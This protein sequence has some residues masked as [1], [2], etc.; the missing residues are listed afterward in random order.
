MWMDD[1]LS[2]T[3]RQTQYA[4]A[5]DNNS[6]CWKHSIIH[7]LVEKYANPWILQ[8]VETS[9]GRINIKQAFLL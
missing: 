3:Y 5:N 1:H 4:K 9:F 6:L 7:S 2:Q 8:V